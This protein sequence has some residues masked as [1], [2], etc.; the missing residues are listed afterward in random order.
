MENASATFLDA[1]RK[2]MTAIRVAVGAATIDPNRLTCAERLQYEGYS[3]REA[4]AK[5]TLKLSRQGMPIRQ[6]SARPATAASLC[7]TCCAA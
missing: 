4:T 7:A 5:A 2:S 3:L 1:V 6:S